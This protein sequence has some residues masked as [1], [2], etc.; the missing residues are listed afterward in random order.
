MTGRTPVAGWVQDQG[1]WPAAQTYLEA[2]DTSRRRV[3]RALLLSTADVRAEAIGRLYLRDDGADLAGLL[4]GL[5]EK[6][7]ARQWFIERLRGG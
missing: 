3:L 5:D 4:I 7:W 6:E 1:R 2:L